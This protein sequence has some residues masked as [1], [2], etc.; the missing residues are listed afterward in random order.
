MNEK[1]IKNEQNQNNLKKKKKKSQ[2][3][4][5]HFEYFSKILQSFSSSMH[6]LQL[7]MQEKQLFQKKIKTSS[8]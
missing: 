2:I 8:E 5:F 7:A 4:I 1:E 6:Y 3:T